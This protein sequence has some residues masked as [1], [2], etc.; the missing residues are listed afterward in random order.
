MRTAPACRNNPWAGFTL[1]ELMIVIIVATLLASIAIPSY[2]SQMRKSRRTE[3]KSALLELAAR[4]ERFF[5]TNSAYTN[6]AN[7]LGYSSSG[8]TL[9]QFPVGSNYYQISA[10]VGTNIPSGC[11]AAQADGKNA[12]YLLQAT[13]IGT[14]AK[15]LACAKFTVDN[16]GIQS[17]LD[18][19]GAAA[20][21]CW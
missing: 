9:F 15:D 13:A 19:T 14:Q 7:N 8:Q 10:C 4:E 6:D 21:N 3:A 5:S 11:D 16:T 17:A 12:T 18:S 20:S 1:V 2:T